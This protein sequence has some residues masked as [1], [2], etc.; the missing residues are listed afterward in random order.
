M[1]SRCVSIDLKARVPAL[2][3]DGYTV[4]QICDILDIKKTLAYS[5]LSNH[6]RYGATY[7]IHTR[8]VLQLFASRNGRPGV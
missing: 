3:H 4:R 6:V 1:P 8:R 5:C 2:F 7:N